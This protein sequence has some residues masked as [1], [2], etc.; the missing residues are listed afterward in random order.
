MMAEY[1][2]L[3]EAMQEA[4]PLRTLVNTVGAGLG[5][6]PGSLT[7]FKTVAW[8]DN[9]RALSLANLEPAQHTPRSR[10]YS[11]KVHWCKSHLTKLGP[12][13]VTVEKIATE[14][15]LAGM[16]TKPLLWESFVR[17]RFQ[18]IGW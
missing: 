13:P 7:Q 10:Y 16:F 8:E 2:P 18:L 17:L 12:K 9:S 15:Q 11:V 3:S 5:M 1:C 6:D 14:H 4:L